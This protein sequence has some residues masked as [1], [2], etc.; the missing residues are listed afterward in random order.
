VGL[1]RQQRSGFAT[2]VLR[3]NI[4]CLLH[5]CDL[6]ETENRGKYQR[7]DG[8]KRPSCIN[9]AGLPDAPGGVCHGLVGPSNEVGLEVKRDD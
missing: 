3:L 6:D 8:S 1:G 4:G 5:P 9:V 7:K 2:T